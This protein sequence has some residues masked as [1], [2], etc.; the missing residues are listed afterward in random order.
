V[1]KAKLYFLETRPQFLLL[2]VALVL[3]GSALAA[4]TLSG[5]GKLGSFNVLYMLLAMVGLALIHGSVDALNDWH[6]YDKS[7]IDKATRQTPFS[8]G[9]GLVPTG[10]LTARDALIVGVGTLVVGCAIGLYLAWVSFQATGAATL[11]IIGIIGALSVVL[12]TPL[13][14]KI[15]LGE[16]FAGLGLGTLPV[17]GT[18]YLMT[19]TIDTA[20]WVSSI[21]AFL[22]TYNLLLL[23]EFPD[24][25]ADIAGGRHHMI[26]LLGK[27]R[28]RWLYVAA[29]VGAYVAIAA[30]V[31]LG[32]LTPWA[33][34]ALV[35]GIFAFKAISGAIKDY[36]S[37]EKLIP[38]QGANVIAVLS[39]NALLA[40]GYLVATL[41][42]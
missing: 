5:E 17:I 32:I 20:A 2:S 24:M 31:A 18:Y 27:K 38:A 10:K 29:E 1:S 12:Y 40:I 30:G 4:W 25:D 22:L 34:V 26:V 3:H 33:L 15:G 36:E 35:A 13:F 21:P 19:G 9:S 11:L 37:F 39:T 42:R 14:T 16:I 7:G 28:G 8:G 23:N 41:T 6:D